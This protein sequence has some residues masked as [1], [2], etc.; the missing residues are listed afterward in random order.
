MRDLRAAPA[1]VTRNLN[2]VFIC[3][4]ETSRAKHK[5]KR[6][7]FAHQNE[8][9]EMV[10]PFLFVSPYVWGLT[11]NASHG[12]RMIDSLRGIYILRREYWLPLH[13]QTCFCFIGPCR[14]FLS[15]GGWR[16]SR[17][18]DLIMHLVLY[19]PCDSRGR[20]SKLHAIV[21]SFFFFFWPSKSA[22]LMRKKLSSFCWSIPDFMFVAH[23][24]FFSFFLVP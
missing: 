24:S 1:L 9:F 16:L 11:L 12:P 23:E 20:E 10:R 4:S 6:C 22:I 15:H 5:V 3:W 7:Y 13:P 19:F 14:H 21:L 2:M 8:L 18:M 17:M